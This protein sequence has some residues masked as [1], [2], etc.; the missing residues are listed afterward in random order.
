[1]TQLI[2]DKPEEK[3]IAIFVVD[4]HE[5]F[6]R[7]V[8]MSVSKW[9][10]IVIT[11]EASNGKELLELLEKEIP[12]VVILN[13]TMP[14]MNGIETL[15]IVKKKYPYLKVIILTMHNDIRMIKKMMQLGA[16]SYLTKNMDGDII[17]QAIKCV[18]EYNYYYSDPM[19]RAFL[20]LNPPLVPMGKDF[21]VKEQQLLDLLAEN[22]TESQ[23]A[24]IMD[25]SKNTV[26][27]LIDRLTKRRLDKSS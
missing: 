20:D 11:K 16:N 9:P 18:H 27:V 26:A 3:K 23:I 4:D 17:C 10:E 12:D 24:D 8:R 14:I 25:I 13:I 21:T 5:L 19:A 15:P 22:K 7:G 6:R 1:M 2:P